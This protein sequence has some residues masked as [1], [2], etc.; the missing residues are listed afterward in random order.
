MY[1]LQRLRQAERAVGISGESLLLQRT[2]T[3]RGGVIVKKYTIF[4]CWATIV[5][6][7]LCSFGALLAWVMM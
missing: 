6:G 2:S 5:V 7:L 1:A 4:L 3:G